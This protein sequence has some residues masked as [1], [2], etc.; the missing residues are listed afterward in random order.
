MRFGDYPG[1]F[2]GDPIVPGAA[3]LRA[4]AAASER[5][6]VGLE[7]VRFLGIV[8]PGDEVDLDLRV[9]GD[10]VRFTVRRDGVDV[11]RGIGRLG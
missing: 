6:I 2:P 8:R 5:P 1:H 7:R 10:L 11:A 9:D 3:L 4:V